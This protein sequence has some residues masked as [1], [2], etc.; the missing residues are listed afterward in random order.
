MT[1]KIYIVNVTT[2]EDITE[3]FC[4][5]DDAEQARKVSSNLNEGFDEN[6]E[7]KYAHV[8][9]AHLIPQDS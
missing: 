7:F 4:A 5:Y 1:K 3:L 8:S 2:A 9:I 6:Q